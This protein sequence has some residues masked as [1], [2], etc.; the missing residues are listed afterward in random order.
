MKIAVMGS[1]GVG[2]YYGGMLAQGGHEVVFI[3]RGAH[4]EA[5]RKRGLEVKSVHGDFT[6]PA[7]DATDRPA[8]VGPVELI[9]VCVKTL[10][11][12]RAAESMRPMVEQETS[13]LSFQ[14]G[15]DA[16]ERIGAVV[17]MDHMMGAATWLSSAIEAPG[18]IRQVSQFRRIVLGE[19]D[20]RI[21]PRAEGLAEA[22]QSTGATVE[23]S[24]NIMKVLWTKFVFISAISGV[25]SLT[26]LPMGD[27]R[28]VA[29]TRALLIGLMTEVKAV[30]RASGVELDPDV[31]D[32]I[33]N[34]LDH[35]GP[36]IKPSMQR[37]VEAGRCSELDSMVGIVG[38]KARELDVHT[39][40]TDMVYAALLPGEMKAREQ[41]R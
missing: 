31:I 16:A 7:V 2:G 26:R 25:G 13:V 29:E 40:A 3:A 36:D 39:P 21:T 5:L 8:E 11:T 19:L 33:L 9:I 37:D 41:D 20:G 22:L 38:R 17:G 30:S 27:Y 4:L 12:E 18:V 1:G 32:G 34:L 35:A 6:L 24:D 15:I 10:A 23:I 14:N 28:S